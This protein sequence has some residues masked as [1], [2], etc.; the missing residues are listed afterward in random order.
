MADSD[1]NMWV[2]KNENSGAWVEYKF[3]YD[4]QIGQIEFKQRDDVKNQAS[5]I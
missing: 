1:N 2:A 4:Y 5:K 3:K